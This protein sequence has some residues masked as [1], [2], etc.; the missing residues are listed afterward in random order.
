MIK[1]KGCIGDEGVGEST[2]SSHPNRNHLALHFVAMWKWLT[3]LAVKPES[4]R[5]EPRT[6]EHH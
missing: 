3:R 6:E 1:N 5:Q 4:P 2:I